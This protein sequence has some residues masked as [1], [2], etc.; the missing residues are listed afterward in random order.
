M[1]LSLTIFQDFIWNTYFPYDSI[2]RR[3]W[4]EDSSESSSESGSLVLEPMDMES[5]YFVVLLVLIALA[6][7]V[8]VLCCELK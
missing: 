3:R 4:R 7:S 5:L 6:A 2:V 1:L 8:A